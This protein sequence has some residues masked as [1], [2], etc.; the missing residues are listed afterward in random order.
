MARYTASPAEAD[1]WLR[2]YRARFVEETAKGNHIYWIPSEETWVV[3][4]PGR[5]GNVS[6]EMKTGAKP[7][8]C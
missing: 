8:G 6:L 4:R 1:E 3:V 7:C 2:S 5:G